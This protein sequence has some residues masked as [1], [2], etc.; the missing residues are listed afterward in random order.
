MNNKANVRDYLSV[1]PENGRIYANIDVMD[2]VLIDRTA[3]WDALKAENERLREA[4]EFYAEEE[5]YHFT[6]EQGRPLRR[7][8]PIDKD[9]GKAARRALKGE[10]E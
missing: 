2:K 1:H 5:L 6:V 3:E 9:N 7:Y 8:R 4:L 10:L